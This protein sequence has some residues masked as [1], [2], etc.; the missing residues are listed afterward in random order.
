MKNQTLAGIILLLSVGVHGCQTLPDFPSL[1]LTVPDL[2][3]VYLT[4]H[5]HLAADPKTVEDIISAFRQAEE[6]I[7]QGNLDGTMSF[8]AHNYRHRNFNPV[9][10]RPI[11]KRWFEEYRDLSITHMFSYIEVKATEEALTA[12][13]ICTGSLWGLSKQT[14]EHIN[15]DSWSDNEHYL[16]YENGGWR[17]QGHQWEFLME[18]ETRAMRPPHPLF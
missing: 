12:R 5:A 8:Y 16:V 18:K 9:T 6:A 10:L 1:Y 3:G 13:V 2:R 7:A 4:R 15:I 14:G 11:W 17:S